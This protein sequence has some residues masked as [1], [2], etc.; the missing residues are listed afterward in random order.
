MSKKKYK[1]E[2]TTIKIPYYCEDDSFESYLNDIR[3]QYSN[4]YRKAYKVLTDDKLPNDKKA[5]NHFINNIVKTD[6]T[7]IYQNMDSW[8]CQSIMVHVAGQ[9][10]SDKEIH[11]D[12]P[13]FKRIH[14]GK[15]NFHRRR[16]G[17]ISNEEWKELRLCKLNVEGEA[18]QGGNRKFKFS[19]Y[20]ID[21]KPKRGVSFN[22]SFDIA[23]MRGNWSIYKKMVKYAND[24]R[25]PIK[26]SIDKR[27]IYLTVNND[28]IM[29]CQVE[30]NAI[31]LKNKKFDGSYLKHNTGNYVGIDSNPNNYGVVYYDKAGKLLHQEV[32]QLN[33][34]T[35]KKINR[36][37][38]LHE[39]REI[40]WAIIRKCEHYKIDYVIAEDLSFKQGDKGIGRNYNRLC[41]NQF[42]FNEFFRIIA[43][44]VEVC[45]VNAA[46]SST[47]GN[48]MYS[49][50][51]PIAAAK[52]V[53]R[54]G[55]SCLLDRNYGLFY[56]KLRQMYFANLGLKAHFT[57]WI[58][59][60]NSI[61]TAG[62]RYRNSLP[63][64]GFKNYSSYKSLV[65]IHYN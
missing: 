48:L 16:R 61:K 34:L 3:M 26:V 41:N 14:G 22:L 2:V 37:K 20:S 38:L 15:K 13:T 4:L 49:D 1:V 30:D 7:G 35:G 42:L 36:N 11:K 32:Y 23:D 24:R 25:I 6:A 50:S 46:Y 5:I 58:S 40:A 64:D 10:A 53:A 54:R 8:M 9:V 43:K 44:K 60:H 59:L 45:T 33:Q 52:E 57:D 29:A 27:Y 39:I 51:D 56:P 18:P 55:K 28:K 31:D 19:D 21:Y 63:T 47:I 17:I 12:N 65:I 62:L